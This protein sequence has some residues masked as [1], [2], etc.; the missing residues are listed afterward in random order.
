[1]KVGNSIR[2]RI[3]FG[4]LGLILFV[5]LS[6]SGFSYIV[7]KGKIEKDVTGNLS[8]LAERLAENY[9]FAIEK[10]FLQMTTLARNLSIDYNDP[11]MWSV[12]AKESEVLGF[13]SM[14]PA[15]LNGILHL[16]NGA[17]VDLSERAYVK[18]VLNEGLP[19]ISDPVFSKVKGEEDLFT[20]LIAVPI[21][22]GRKLTG[23]LIGQK[24]AEF[25]TKSLGVGY[26][27][28]T[29]VQFVLNRDSVT[30]AHTDFENVVARN[31]L[32]ELSGKNPDLEGLGN[33]ARKMIAGETGIGQYEREGLNKYVGYAPVD[34]TDWSA[35][36]TV[37]S[38]EIFSTLEDLTRFLILISIAVLAFGVVI[39]VLIGKTLTKPMLQVRDAVN[40][41]AEGEADLTRSIKINRKDEIQ[42]LSEGF[43]RFINKLRQLIIEIRNSTNISNELKNN[44]AMSAEET[45][46]SLEE[47]S[48]NTGSMNNQVEKINE[49]LQNN[50]SVTE[51]I[52][53]N[54]ESMDK[55]IINQSAMV[56]ESTAA[57]TQMISSLNSVNSVT[58]TKMIS[59]R[60][61]KEV[62]T[63][64]KVHLSHTNEA[65]RNVVTN[66]EQIQSMAVTI[67]NIAS[68]TN[69][70][71]MN[72]AI[73]AAHAGDSGRGF[74]VV[75]EEIRKLADSAGVSAHQISESVKDIT[76]FV[77]QTETNSHQLTVSFESIEKEVE[78]TINAFSEI[79]QSVQELTQGGSQILEATQELS[80]VTSSVQT[81]SGEI[82]ESASVILSSSEDLKIISGQIVD[83]MN[84]ITKGN[85][86]IV[87]SM[88]SILQDISKLGE[89]IDHIQ[90]LFRRF[91][92]DA[93][94]D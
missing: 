54:I 77:N 11:E 17:S 51:E 31:N 34:F 55:Q 21:Y 64:G 35:A 80:Q 43:N 4:Y 76:S 36:I 19:V 22:D 63:E 87:G 1:M 50:V 68:Q 38:Y 46:S 65:I 16:A 20:V 40:E 49:N 92:V 94:Q 47:I 72:A 58:N 24:D 86:D 57:I 18:K 82:R 89:S 88:Q 25:L 84:E 29:S 23:I 9:S 74:A 45:S 44:V 79:G 6:I 3:L 83:G 61:L 13:N 5:C 60:H 93:D 48:A 28:S 41:I 66:V 26:F 39:S 32:I 91:T 67:D 15:D 56:E 81:S 37:N 27:G 75:A 71:S 69:L 70:L 33:I 42:E 10:T 78:S 59:T 52:T 12:L 85:T 8:R 30:I 53:A 62:A 14:S 7:L 2:T 73:E 90:E